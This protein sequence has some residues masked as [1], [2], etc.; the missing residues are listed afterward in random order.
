MER[1]L[2]IILP[3]VRNGSD[4]INY[5]HLLHRYILAVKNI[6]PR[7]ENFF[8][9]GSTEEE[10]RIYKVPVQFSQ[11]EEMLAQVDKCPN[12]EDTF[13]LLGLWNGMEQ[14][15]DGCSFQ[16]NFS[17]ENSNNMYFDHLANAKFYFPLFHNKL[18]DGITRE[19]HQLVLL[20]FDVLPCSFITEY[21]FNYISQYDGIPD[22]IVGSVLYGRKN[23]LDGIE[24]VRHDINDELVVLSSVAEKFD[25]RNPEH[26]KKAHAWEKQLLRNPRFRQLLLR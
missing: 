21:D 9:Q 24:G 4:F 2:N 13:F 23:D 20:A 7:Y 1:Y 22:L 11:F 19:I 12:I 10:A 5:L 17:N 18:D 3:K 16:L 26:V 15:E 14:Q 6:S 8:L 25:S